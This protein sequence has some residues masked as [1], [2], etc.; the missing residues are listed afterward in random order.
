MGYMY[1]NPQMNNPHAPYGPQ[2]YGPGPQGYYGNNMYHQPAPQSQSRSIDH[3]QMRHSKPMDNPPP[4]QS[5][6]FEMQ[7]HAQNG[8]AE[9]YYRP[10]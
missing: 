6:H 3:S 7:G 4:Y 2:S 8:S 9:K 10:N 1:N 5:Q